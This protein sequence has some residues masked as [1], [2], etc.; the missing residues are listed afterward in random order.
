MAVRSASELRL[1]LT[2]VEAARTLGISMDS[3]ER[4]V[5]PEVRAVVRGR[6][7]LY[8]LSELQRWIEKNSIPPAV[9]TPGTGSVG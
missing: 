2:R 3:F 6:L 7:R 1:T 5:Q 4:H 9:E 8:P